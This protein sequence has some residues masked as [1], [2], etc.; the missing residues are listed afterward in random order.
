MEDWKTGKNGPTKQNKTKTNATPN[1]CPSYGTSHRPGGRDLGPKRPWRRGGG[2]GA[3]PGAPELPGPGPAL[4]GNGTAGAHGKDKPLET[5]HPTQM[6]PEPRKATR[7][8]PTHPAQP[9]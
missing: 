1:L 9:N 5:A 6:K 8:H 3:H 7:T 4:A 2:M